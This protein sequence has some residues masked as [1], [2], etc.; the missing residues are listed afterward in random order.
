M[1]GDGAGVVS[2]TSEPALIEPIDVNI[3]ESAIEETTEVVFDSDRNRMIPS[4]ADD[5]A[6]GGDDILAARDYLQQLQ[7]GSVR[8]LAEWLLGTSRGVWHTEAEHLE[9]LVAG[10]RAGRLNPETELGRVLPPYSRAIEAICENPNLPALITAHFCATSTPPNAWAKS[11]AAAIIVLSAMDMVVRTRS[12]L[13][14]G[15]DRERSSR[16]QMR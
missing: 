5:A 13:E 4:G 9:T 12:F 8:E 2:E 15:V 7:E 6:K 10:L 3:G 1:P 14:T 11:G 16:S